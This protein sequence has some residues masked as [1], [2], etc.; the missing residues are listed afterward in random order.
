MRNFAWWLFAVAVAASGCGRSSG[1]PVLTAPFTDDF[2]GSELGPV[3]RNTGGPYEIV[4]GELHVAGAHNHPLW[5]RKRLPD[6]VRVSL[7]VRSESRD[8]D[9]KF[10]LFGD[11]VSFAR[12]SSYVATGYVLV[13]G[14]WR[15]T[16]SEIARLDEHG[17]DVSDRR[18]VRVERGRT[19]ALK[20][21]RR[22]GRLQWWVDGELLLEYDD[23]LPLKGARHDHFGVNNW[24]TPLYFD[25]VRVEPL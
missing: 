13:F 7:D 25:N 23:P 16:K 4:S 2:S 15:N 22:G 5:L 6:D 18:D 20:A 17:S 19:Y 11:G 10:E 12:Q 24:E 21:E 3:W 1:D 14:G 8:G 9:I